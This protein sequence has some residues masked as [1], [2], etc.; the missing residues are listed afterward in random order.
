MEVSVFPVYFF[1]HYQYKNIVT[2]KSLQISMDCRD[3]LIAI[4]IAGR[5]AACNPLFR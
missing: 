2:K 5:R 1:V 3:F 4:G